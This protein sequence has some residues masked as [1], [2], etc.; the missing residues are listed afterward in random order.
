MHCEKSG[1]RCT[2]TAVEVSGKKYC[3]DSCAQLA[4]TETGLGQTCL[5]GH[6]GCDNV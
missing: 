1:C 4:A 3:S 5:C 2:E 6:D